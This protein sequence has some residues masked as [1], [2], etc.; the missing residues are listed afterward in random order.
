MEEERI[1]L[2]SWL[3]GYNLDDMGQLDT[4]DFIHYGQIFR[5][6]KEGNTALEISRKVNLP[7]V[8]LAKMQGEYTYTFYRQIFEQWQKDKILR[9]IARLGDVEDVE[10]I[11]EKIDYLLSSRNDVKADTGW[12]ELFLNEI[13]R[14]SKTK[15]VKYGLPTLDKLTG[16]M[17]RKE[18]TSLAARPSVG[19]SALALQIAMKVQADGNKVLY[20]PLEMSV[21]QTMERMVIAKG[22]ADTNSLRS[23]KVD[24]LKASF[25][26]DYLHGIEQS[27]KL[28]IYEGC[29]SLERIQTAIQQ[30]KPFLVVID[31]L[32]Q[33]KAAK[34]FGSVRERFSHMTNNLKAIAMK[35]DV[36]ILMLCQTNRGAQSVRPT[37]ADL[38]ESGSI[39]EDSDNVILL[40]RLNPADAD[41]PADWQTERPIL[42]DLAKQR[43]GGTGNFVAAF[44][45]RGFN[46]YERYTR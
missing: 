3:L 8:E 40:H 2:G 14:R 22:Y 25:A 45:S 15:P 11:Q 6:L 46:F 20:F 34:T 24:P 23:G 7:I 43:N 39:E 41:N 18:L 30:E 26:A 37:M 1:L 27:G 29:S 32:T 19:K 44:N 36:S 5:L 31:Q 28:K 16:G 4:T 12:G 17:R 38:K 42:V 35:E 21:M 9:Q 13:D 10:A 33:M